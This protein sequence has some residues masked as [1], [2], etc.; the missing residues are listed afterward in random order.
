MQKKEF[1]HKLLYSALVQLRA[2]A[3]ERN[4]KVAFRIC[5]LLHNVPMKLLHA[6]TEA[7]FEAIYQELSDYV[8]STGMRKW[9]DRVEN[10]VI[11]RVKI[12]FDRKD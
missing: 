8:D 1:I 12:S 3:V 4:D 10:P 11:H 9:F 6:T 2:D 5:D 7:D